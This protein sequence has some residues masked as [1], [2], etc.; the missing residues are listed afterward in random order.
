[1]RA[2]GISSKVPLSV[3]SR[4]TKSPAATPRAL[5]TSSGNVARPSSSKV[6]NVVTGVID[7]LLER[8]NSAPGTVT[9]SR[10][11][12]K[13]FGEYGIYTTTL[14]GSTDVT[15]HVVDLQPDELR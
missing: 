15:T 12:R 9:P 11:A 6:R 2:A 5:R 7:R 1:M 8:Q 3:R 4:S 10:V 14:L 13:S